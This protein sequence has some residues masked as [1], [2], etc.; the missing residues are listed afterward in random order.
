MN[1]TPPVEVYFFW[2]I[3]FY[4]GNCHRQQEHVQER[5]NSNQPH[6]GIRPPVVRGWAAK[7]ELAT[8]ATLRFL[9]AMQTGRRVFLHKFYYLIDRIRA[10]QGLPPC[11]PV[12]QHHHSS[13]KQEATLSRAAAALQRITGWFISALAGPSYLPIRRGKCSRSCMERPSFT[14]RTHAWVPFGFGSNNENLLQSTWQGDEVVANTRMG[15]LW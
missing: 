5:L 7:K 2:Y 11:T 1:Q 10:K 3:M 8:G 12:H 6:L 15:G 9:T 4:G 14:E 13:L